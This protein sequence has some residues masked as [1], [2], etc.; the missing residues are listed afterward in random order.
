MHA[1]LGN[2]LQQEISHRGVFINTYIYIYVILQSLSFPPGCEGRLAVTGAMSKTFLAGFT[3]K[4][5]TQEI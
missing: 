1:P 3:V 2:V 5:G 4:K